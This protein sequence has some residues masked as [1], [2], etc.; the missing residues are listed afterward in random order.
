MLNQ[1]IVNLQHGM[2]HILNIGAY[3]HILFLIVLCVPYLFKD[4][5]RILFLVTVFTLGHTVSL[6]LATYDVVIIKRSLIK[7]LIPVTIFIIALYNIFTAGKKAHNEKVGI[8]FLSTMFLGVIHGMGYVN[9]FESLLGASDNKWIVLIEV[10]L[11]IELGQL[12]VAFI[13]VFIGFLCQTIFRFSKRDWVMVLSSVVVGAL[14]PILT[15]SGIF[16]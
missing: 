1:F 5:K 12:I 9:T 15:Q 6:L 13:I 14:I 3:D 16:F 2:N 4:W 8:L 10:S 7:F 11:G